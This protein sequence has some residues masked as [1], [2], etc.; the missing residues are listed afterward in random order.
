M[1]RGMRLF[2]T[3]TAC[4]LSLPF[5]QD[6]AAG[7][8]RSVIIGFRQSPGATEQALVTG[9][10]GR[11]NRK[12][13]H[14][15]AVTA[16][17]PE[18]EID[19]LR[20]NP[21]VAYVAENTTYAV[22]PTLPGTELENSWN[23]D[24][25]GARGAHNASILGTGVKVA[26]IDTGIVTDH[27]ELIHAYKGG[28]D[29]AGNDDDPTDEASNSHGTLVAGVIASAGNSTGTLGVA[30]AVSLYAV[31]VF[32]GS[33]GTVEHLVAGI[34]WAIDN[35]MD[36]INLSNG[37]GPD[38]NPAVTEA[39]AK[40]ETAGILVVAAVGNSAASP[41]SHPAAIPSVVAVTA[42]DRNKQ[43]A[44]FAPTGSEIDLSAPGVDINSTAKGGYDTMS[45]SSFA[46]PHVTGVAALLLS[47]GL[48]DENGNG[49]HLDELKARL[50]NSAE[51]LGNPCQDQVFGHGM[52]HAA[53]AL[54]LEP[55]PERTVNCSGLGDPVDPF[56][57]VRQS[58]NNTEDAVEAT[59]G[60]G[61]YAI[62]I[63]NNGLKQI[64]LMVYKNGAFVPEL[65]GTMK[66][67]RKTAR[68]AILPFDASTGPYQVVF[69]PTGKF[70]TSATLMFNPPESVLPKA[71]TG[72]NRKAKYLQ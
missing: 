16:T 40:A 63:F 20:S 39:I 38:P 10:K 33:L 15:H 53:R 27:P 4:V 32:T 17:L 22:S 72:N 13:R 51:D 18:G 56:T 11:V 8:D 48:G 35:Q 9:K 21:N 54:G 65:S 1:N 70:G 25:I 36:I 52:V 30:P 45:G 2:L 60:G 55:I 29:I 3:L 64:S 50:F 19:A 58:R 43:V 34:E 49:S 68:G 69:I 47:S 57:L 26:V 28:I 37:I 7:A 61:L 59:L 66:F 46:A 14:L 42:M 71:N 62:A 41:V 31:K 24:L 23:L 12:F 44:A 6:L 5:G 67:N